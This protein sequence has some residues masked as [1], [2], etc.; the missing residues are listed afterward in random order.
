MGQQNINHG[1]DPGDGT[2]DI[3]FLAFKAIDENFDDVY[4][5]FH[6][7]GDI[8]F[9][10]NISAIFGTVSDASISY[11]GINLVIDPKLI[12]SG[13]VDLQGSLQATDQMA[14]G[15]VATLGGVSGDTIIQASETVAIDGTSEAGAIVLELTTS[16]TGVS[17][18]PR[19]ILSTVTTR[20]SGSQASPIGIKSLLVQDS[21]GQFK[22]GSRSGVPYQSAMHAEIHSESGSAALNEVANIAVMWPS[23]SG[24]K[25][26]DLYGIFIGDQGTAGITNSYGIYIQHPSFGS[27]TMSAGIWIDRIF[28]G[29]P[30]TTYGIVLGEDSDTGGIFFGAAQDAS[31]LYDG[32]NLVIDPKLIGSGYLDVLGA[33]HAD[34]FIMNT[35]Q[36]YILNAA[37]VLDRTLLASASA[38]AI[39]NNNV[40]AALITDLQT[41][42]I[43][44]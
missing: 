23:F 4:G 44:A 42:G 28:G 13:Y 26:T 1:T 10:D 40:L 14:I 35:Q 9:N 39:N 25:P 20:G 8:T 22:L 16:G 7:T 30:T 41:A 18:L 6:P 43:I 38:S 19:G 24:G 34:S 17:Q 2:G 27:P 37:S 11:D 33:I 21:T 15:S 12:G 5:D 32:T 3:L 29:S 36:T 31:I